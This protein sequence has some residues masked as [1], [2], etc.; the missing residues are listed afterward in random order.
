[1]ALQMSAV[2]QSRSTPD[3]LGVRPWKNS[4]SGA[5]LGRTD[6]TNA[7]ME[8]FAEKFSTLNG[9]AQH[10]RLKPSSINGSNNITKS[11]LIRRYECAILYLKQS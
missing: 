2:G 1:M 4:S 6:I 8:R 9:L 10:V 7:S 3:H 5:I 11:G